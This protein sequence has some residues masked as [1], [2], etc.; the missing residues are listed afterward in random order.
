VASGHIR[1]Y[2]GG[3]FVPQ[4]IVDAVKEQLA[5]KTTLSVPEHEVMV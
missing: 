1:K 2:D 4:Q 5:G 3:P